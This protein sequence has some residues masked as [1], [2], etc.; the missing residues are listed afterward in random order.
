MDIP[1]YLKKSEEDKVKL[2]AIVF[3]THGLSNPLEFQSQ[4]Y[5]SGDLHSHYYCKRKTPKGSQQ[6]WLLKLE[7]EYQTQ[8]PY[9]YKATLIEK[10]RDIADDWKEDV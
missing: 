2:K 4:E 9:T 8:P 5:L 7:T 6:L 3:L 10:H 1:I